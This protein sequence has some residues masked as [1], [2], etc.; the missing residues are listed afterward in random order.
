MNE[1]EFSPKNILN[2]KLNGG[3]IARMLLIAEIQTGETISQLIAGI[4]FNAFLQEPIITREAFLG[5]VEAM[6]TEIK[7]GRQPEITELEK[8]QAWALFT[9]SKPSRL[10]KGFEWGA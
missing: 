2:L 7:E 1:F 10:S 6:R 9:S 8:R 4:N 5:M 3:Q